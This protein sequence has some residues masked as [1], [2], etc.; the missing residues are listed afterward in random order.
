M[1][2]KELIRRAILGSREAQQECTDKWI[3]LPCPCCKSDAEFVTEVANFSGEPEQEFHA[4]RC[5]SC[6]LK[7]GLYKTYR[8][9]L[10]KWNTRNVSLL[11]ETSICSHEFEELF[12]CSDDDYKIYTNRVKIWRNGESFKK[13]MVCKSAE[14]YLQRSITMENNKEL[15]RCALLGNQESQV[16]CTNQGI[17][18][19][20]PYCGGDAELRHLSHETSFSETIDVFCVTCKKC[21]CNPFE[22][23]D[24]NLFYTSKGI[25]KAKLLKQK[26]LEKWNTRPA[27]P[28]GR[29]KDCF[30]YH[31]E[32]PGV[33]YCSRDD[34]GREETNFCSEFEPKE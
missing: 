28:I 6:F 17:V 25:Q 8:D 2:D 19:P 33:G 4:V 23:S 15:I 1:T 34:Q 12:Y 10:H 30:H 16:Q 14:W 32:G 29:C 22:F 24:Y 7:T 3:S 31:S 21:G 5:K 18:L 26:A 11:L 27:P 20:C 9:A 13:L